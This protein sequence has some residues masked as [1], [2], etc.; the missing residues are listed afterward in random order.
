MEILKPKHI[1]LKGKQV[2]ILGMGKSGCA[3]AELAHYLGASVF[4]SE[5]GKTPIPED[6]S[7]IG[8]QGETGGHTDKIFEGDLLILSPGIPQNDPLL[9]T[10]RD[11]NIPVIGEI[12]FASWFTDAPIIGVTGSNGKTTT[13]HLLVKMCQS[14]SIKGVLAGNVGIPFSQ[15]VLEDLRHP[16]PHRVHILEISSFQM[17]QILHFK[18]KVSVFLNITPDHLDRYDSMAEYIQ[19]KLNMV[20]NQTQDDYIVYNGDDPILRDA[21]KDHPAQRIPFSLHTMSECLYTLNKT[22]IY[23]EEHAT[24]IHLDQ[25]ALPGQHNLSNAL[26]AAT[27]ATLIGSPKDRII[28]VMSS[29][30]GVEHRLERVTEISGV[31]YYNDSKATNVDAV[32]VALDSFTEPTL[33]ILG[34]KDKGGNFEQL[35]PH[36]HNNVKEIIAYGQAGDKIAAALRDAVRF[37]QV[38]NLEDA[39]AMSQNHAEPGDIVLLSPGC[40]SFDQFPN[41]EERGKSFKKWVRELE[42]NQ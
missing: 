8:I 5:R 37:E 25:L 11:K 39:V 30:S 16:E 31:T 19:A 14:E 2:T 40:A 28:Q 10:A 23:D 33:L 17:E 42:K 4:M 21:F 12:E 7:G 29:F 15:T 32:K 36:T 35:L 13:V 38:F 20:Q 24:L 26:G 9:K 27:A 1:D 34:G 22:K 41:F 3:A 6:L 18:P